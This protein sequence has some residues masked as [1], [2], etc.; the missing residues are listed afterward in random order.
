MKISFPN[1]KKLKSK[2]TKVLKDNLDPQWN[3]SFE[4]E[5][6]DVEKFSFGALKLEIFDKDFMMHD[7]L[8]SLVMFMDEVFELK[9]EWAINDFF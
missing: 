8:G 2:K 1:Q 3:E 7:S 4:Y 5:L 9:G 6:K